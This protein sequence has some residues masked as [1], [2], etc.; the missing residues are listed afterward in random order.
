MRDPISAFFFWSISLS[1]SLHLRGLS[2]F[3]FFWEFLEVSFHFSFRRPIPIV[4]YGVYFIGLNLSSFT[5][6]EEL[7]RKLLKMIGLQC[8]LQS[9][10]SM[11]LKSF[12]LAKLEEESGQ[13]VNLNVGVC[14]C[15]NTNFV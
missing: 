1:L 6:D 9:I 11:L 14:G 12:T 8:K 5:S 3:N 10:V 13:L 4:I 7:F 2:D 15:L